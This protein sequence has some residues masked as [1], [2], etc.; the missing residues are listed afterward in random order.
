MKQMMT[1]WLLMANILTV[2]ACSSTHQATINEMELLKCPEVRPDVCTMNY[3]P[4]CGR[5]SDGSFKT[6]SNACNACTDPHV[7]SYFPHECN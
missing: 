5:L 6:Y 2:S 4:V 1:R 7:S 3:D